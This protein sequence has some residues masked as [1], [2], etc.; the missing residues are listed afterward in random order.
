MCMLWKYLFLNSRY[1]HLPRG[2]STV[3]KVSFGQTEFHCSTLI[4]RLKWMKWCYIKLRCPD[5]TCFVISLGA[6][7]LIRATLLD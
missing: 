7:S 5:G 4:I 1:A 3:L 6:L 2:F